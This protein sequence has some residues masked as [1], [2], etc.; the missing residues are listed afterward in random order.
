MVEVLYED[1]VPTES[2]IA[3]GSDVPNV[4]K[5]LFREVSKQ[6][7][8]ASPEWK[9]LLDIDTCNLD[10]IPK[11]FRK[12]IEEYGPEEDLAIA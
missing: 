4:N 8:E 1:N 6:I 2:L 3:L 10:I 5:T 7:K 9:G 11:A 12:G